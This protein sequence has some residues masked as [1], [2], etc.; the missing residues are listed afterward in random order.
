MKTKS[1][2]NIKN[3]TVKNIVKNLQSVPVNYYN[4][5]YRKT[6]QIPKTDIIYY[7]FKNFNEYLSHKQLSDETNSIPLSLDE[8]F[9]INPDT[10][11]V[12]LNKNTIDLSLKMNPKT[13]LYKLIAYCFYIKQPDIF[14]NTID[15]LINSLKYQ[16][17]KDVSR[18]D[19]TINK[20]DFNRSYYNRDNTN[21]DDICDIFYQN[22]ID[23]MYQVN[24]TINLN[25]V[26][27]IALLSCQN[28][29]G[30]ISDLITMK[31][32]DILEPEVNSVFQPDKHIN[33]VINSTEISM[34]FIFKSLLI[35]SKNGNLD[36]EYPC[37]H[38]EFNLYIDIRKNIYELKKIYIQYDISKCG[39]EVNTV[40]PSNNTNIDSSSSSSS[41][42]SP[43]FNLNPKIVIPAVL[44]TAG[45]ISTPFILG[46]L[47]GKNKIKNKKKRKTLKK[48]KKK[49]LKLVKI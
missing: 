16:I 3:K 9:L 18:D 6:K 24:K 5:H 21:N 25:I 47:G 7:M 17:G 38:L 2:K 11:P 23:Y 28:V 37:G 36:P 26:N 34:E 20:K 1:N 46:A 13:S 48:I 14:K 41:S 12:G 31:L 39:P 43:K 40:M 32:N 45:I 44:A 27:K 22:I 49:T 35:I 10:F 33:I 19:R 29:Y 4:S 15:T 8:C 30:L 42:P